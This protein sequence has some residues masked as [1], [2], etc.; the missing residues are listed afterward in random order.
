M[1][2]ELDI[3]TNGEAA[4]F[5]VRQSMWHQQGR[6]LQTPPA[7][8]EEALEASGT[9]WEVA[10]V[11]LYV[12]TPSGG[13]YLPVP[14]QAVRRQDNQRVLSVVGP[15]YHPLQNRDAFTILQPLMD[16]GLA[17]WETAG[18]LRQGRD[19]WA[20]VR[21]QVDSPIVQEVFADEVVPY[22][23]LVNNHGGERA[24]TLQETN[25]RVV[26]ANTL[27]ASLGAYRM[28][29]LRGQRI[30]HTLNVASRTTDAVRDLWGGMVERLEAT[31][32]AYRALKETFLTTALFRSL[33][34]DVAL[35]LPKPEGRRDTDRARARFT[36]SVERVTEQRAAVTALW[37]TG[38][39]HTGDSSAWEAYNGLVEAMDHR[40]DVFAVRDNDRLTASLG[41][42]LNTIHQNVLDGLV[43]HATK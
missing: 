31:A 16:A 33:V 36:T 35:P 4:V 38:R 18:A 26:C 2:H 17:V 30:K 12:E 19:V 34:L 14:A 27:R 13:D 11:P 41:G 39:G 5:S 1:A 37:H 8:V 42:R 22:G 25:I 28:N 10:T 23:L 32:I 21:F 9:N 43:A 40:P 24:V 3:R 29:G 6:I 7:T 15:G 20:L